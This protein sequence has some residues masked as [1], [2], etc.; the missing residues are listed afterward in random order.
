MK[1]ALAAIG[2]LAACSAPDRRAESQSAT[3]SS[4]ATGVPT[5]SAAVSAGLASSKSGAGANT[6]ATPA[7]SPPAL[8]PPTKDEAWLAGAESLAPFV[9]VSGAC[10]RTVD[11]S[12]GSEGPRVSYTIDARSVPRSE[13]QAH[14][15][16]AA[17]E[18]NTAIKEEDATMIAQ[19]PGAD[20]A[21][22]LFDGRLSV[23]IMGQ[24]TDKS[25]ALAG[26]I[27]QGPAQA[28]TILD[29]L[30]A[31]SVRHASITHLLDDRREIVVD[32][33]TTKALDSVAG[34]AGLKRIDDTLYAS[35]R[36]TA[37][38]DWLIMLQRRAGGPSLIMSQPVEHACAPVR[39]ADTPP[40]SS[41]RARPPRETPAQDELMNE[42]M[43]GK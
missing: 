9:A 38:T 32:F 29:E 5:P 11:L 4:L 8:S 33:T 1:V 15:R 7:L 42:M 14:F 36:V 23:V 19:A 20:R 31:D 18:T 13:L 43:N 10:A 21:A 27:R 17:A 37:P 12:F 16:A 22:T 2:L 41:S 30:G 26:L 25:A 40:P 28:K 3:A 24:P 39:E 34:R 6:R 35:P